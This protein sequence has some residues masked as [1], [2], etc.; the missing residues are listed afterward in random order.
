MTSGRLH[1][2]V[3][4]CWQVIAAVLLITLLPLFLVYAEWSVIDRHNLKAG[5]K[6]YALSV[7]KGYSAVK[8]NLEL[9]DI[10]NGP[11]A[12]SYSLLVKVLNSEN[13]SQIAV[14]SGFSGSP[15]YFDNRLAGA[16]S[17]MES[18]QKEM[19]VGVTLIEDM[20]ADLKAGQNA[21]EKTLNDHSIL[22]K[23]TVPQCQMKPG[24]MISIPMV[25]GDIWM[26]S[27]GTVTAVNEGV[28][29][30][31]GHRNYY[32]EDEVVLPMHVAKVNSILSKYDL[33]HKIADVG[34]EVGAVLWD[35]NASVI[36]R[37][38]RKANMIPLTFQYFDRHQTSGQDYQME[39][40]QHLQL[41]PKMMGAV[42]SHIV[43]KHA[44]ERLLG[45]DV[46]VDVM[47]TF[48]HLRD[49]VSISQRFSATAVAD[50]MSHLFK[51]LLKGLKNHQLVKA[52]TITLKE[53]KQAESVV[54]VKAYFGRKTAY[55]GDKVILYVELE[56]RAG[57][58][59]TLSVP[60]V[61]HALT[62]SG[63]MP[64]HVVPGDKVL[65]AELLPKML[66]EKINWLSGLLRSD[67]LVVFY[68]DQ[69]GEAFYRQSRV[70]RQVIRV[71]F[72]LEGESETSLNIIGQ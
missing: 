37:I 42:T 64:I 30:A 21:L 14:G 67:D 55:S 36:G 12:G 7:L 25:R 24:S 31:Y 17:Y 45:N 29:L 61:I 1:K 62:P 71:D 19:I 47:I 63:M 23:G 11:D 65:P 68:P 48:D 33:T 4:A 59:Q 22:C 32:W 54:I 9:V 69:H 2:I 10:I 66:D 27:S 57:H 50:G 40:V 70:S 43:A 26:G 44:D 13:G 34:I 60:V 35:G 38:G 51:H 16:I 52:I 18:Y 58:K 39:I 8:I 28:V 20:L 56:D 3:L 46:A 41:L 15:V 5:M 49:P 72:N 6:G 53:L